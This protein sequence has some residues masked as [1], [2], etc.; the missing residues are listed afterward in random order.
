MTS[1]RP[2]EFFLGPGIFLSVPIIALGAVEVFEVL[3]MASG[4]PVDDIETG[5]INYL[6]WVSLPSFIIALFVGGWI[7]AGDRGRETRD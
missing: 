4:L 3:R 2:N 7:E 6:P 5:L 1:Q